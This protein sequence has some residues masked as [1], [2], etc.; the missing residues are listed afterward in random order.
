M[1]TQPSNL[2]PLTSHHNSTAT[3]RPST[4]NAP[5]ECIKDNPR[6]Y[7]AAG[8]ISGPDKL[9]RIL[10]TSILHE[11]FMIGI[12]QQNSTVRTCLQ[13]RSRISLTRYGAG[14]GFP[15]HGRWASSH[16]SQ[17]PGIRCVWMTTAL[18]LWD[19]LEV[20]L[21]CP[22]ATL[23]YMGWGRATQATTQ[24]GFRQRK[25][26]MVHFSSNVSTHTAPYKNQSMRHGAQTW[27][28][29]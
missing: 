16:Q 6:Y 3:V 17:N 2:S 26:R 21:Y 8:E 9:R 7:V 18:S 5:F 14:R 24:F 13:R 11:K 4:L 29:R 10:S 15:K 28:H 22:Y 1:F 20:V 12:C 19:R 27:Q 25:A 23:G